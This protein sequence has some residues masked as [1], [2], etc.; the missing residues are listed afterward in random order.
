MSNDV[1]L[2]GRSLVAARD[3][4]RGLSWA[5]THDYPGRV[6]PHHRSAVAC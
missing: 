6:P 4:N 5:T 3:R 1:L 2:V